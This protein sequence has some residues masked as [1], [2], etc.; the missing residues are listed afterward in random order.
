MADFQSSKTAQEIEEVLTGA[1]TYKSSQSLSES[2]KAL[3][4]EKIG[5]TSYGE[6]IK[7]VSHFDT[8]D[9]L[10]SMVAEPKPGDAYSV[11]AALPYNLYIYDSLASEWKDYGVIRSAD[12]KARFAQNKVVS[13]AD[14][15]EDTNVFVDYSYK[16]R[17][18]I[19]EATGDDFPIVAF[20]P[21]DATCGNFC[22]IAYCFDGYVEIWAKELPTEAMSVPAITFIVQENAE[23]AAGKST[24][25]ITNACGGTPT[26]GISTSQLANGSVTAP[27]LSTDAVTRMFAVTIGGKW[28]G[29]IAPYTQT[30]DV[31]GLPLSDRIF[32]SLNSS[33][34]WET[35][36]NEEE[37]LGKIIKLVAEENKIIV[38]AEEPTTIPLHLKIMVFHGSGVG[39]D[40]DMGGSGNSGGGSGADGFS[41]IA[42]VTQTATGA[43]ITITDKNGTTTARVTNGKD[44]IGI[45]TISIKE[46]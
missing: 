44:G 29:D 23:R 6:G 22:P 9:E 28:D 12:I 39:G 18:P 8:V 20:S 42:N 10:K 27:K 24:K 45:E 35:T 25:G 11:G 37:E 14:W 13:A 26:G 15:E 7:I 33:D 5:A 32:A 38:Y 19:G 1:L 17:I 16:A 34:D 43:V 46:I 31:E 2:E 4:R 41:P 30:I 21:F 40:G 3:V 36:L